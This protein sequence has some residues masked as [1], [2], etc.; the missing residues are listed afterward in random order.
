MYHFCHPTTLPSSFWFKW[1]FC[2]WQCASSA[3]SLLCIHCSLSLSVITFSRGDGEAEEEQQRSLLH[4][5]SSDEGSPNR[6]YIFLLNELNIVFNWSKIAIC[7]LN[8]LLCL[9]VFDTVD[10]QADVT[11][12]CHLLGPASL[13][14]FDRQR[15][16]MKRK[17]KRTKNECK[18]SCS[19]SGNK[20][21]DSIKTWRKVK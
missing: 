19:I 18:G 13:T 4:D 15:L 21:G 5:N 10:P 20:E 9:S 1:T 6:R 8:H 7:F 3:S 12:L 11:C 14:M 2:G 16:E 17:K